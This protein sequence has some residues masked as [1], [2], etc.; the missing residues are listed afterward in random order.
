MGIVLGILSIL[1]GTLL[2][3]SPIVFAFVLIL[4]LGMFLILGG[5][6]AMV[7]AFLIRSAAKKARA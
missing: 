4:M 5:I 1:L 2:L 6:V 7:N 3:M